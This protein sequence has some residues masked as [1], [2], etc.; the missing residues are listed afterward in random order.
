MHQAMFAQLQWFDNRPDL[1]LP[2]F[3]FVARAASG[4]TYLGLTSPVPGQPGSRFSNLSLYHPLDVT[5]DSAHWRHL[6]EM[7]DQARQFPEFR[8]A[9]LLCMDEN[10]LYL[11]NKAGSIGV[12]QQKYLFGNVKKAVAKDEDAILG[13][14]SSIA[15]PLIVAPMRQLE[16]VFLL[17]IMGPAAANA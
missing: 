9:A 5:I 12:Q 14:I 2:D 4:E 7:I 3:F 8:T 16:N 10:R 1:E 11:Q 17:N 15:L 6:R 13:F